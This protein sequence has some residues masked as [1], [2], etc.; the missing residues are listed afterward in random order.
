MC[1]KILLNRNWYRPISKTVINHFHT[2]YRTIFRAY[3][4][5][6]IDQNTW[7]FLNVKDPK[8]PTFYALPKVHKSLTEPPGHPIISGCSSLTENASCLIDS[9]LHPHVTSL[10]S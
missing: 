4:Q 1:K 7:N 2:Q 8:I 5:G 3:H 6:I 10:F 9:Y